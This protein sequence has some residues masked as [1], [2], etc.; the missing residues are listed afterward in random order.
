MNRT[1]DLQ[2]VCLV[3]I[4]VVVFLESVPRTWSGPPQAPTLSAAQRERLKERDKLGERTKTLRAQGKLPEA[5][6]AAEAMLAIE[7]EVLLT[8]APLTRYKMSVLPRATLQ[9]LSR[10]PGWSQ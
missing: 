2:R 7:R 1:V 8:P 4:V 9:N 5:I 6:K 10:L 3:T